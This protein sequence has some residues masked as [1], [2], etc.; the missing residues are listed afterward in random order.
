MLLHWQDELLSGLVAGVEGLHGGEP[1][2]LYLRFVPF[3]F[4]GEH[5]HVQ[6]QGALWLVENGPAQK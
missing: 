1:G 4:T 3:S 5:H 2:D 6:H